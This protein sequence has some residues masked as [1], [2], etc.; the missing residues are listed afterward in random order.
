MFE[1]EVIS[2]RVSRY[3]R[4]SGLVV[5]REVTDHPGAVMIV[6]VDGDQV[7][8]VRQPREAVEE[9][10]LELPAGKMDVLG[11]PPLECA[12]R[13]LAEEVGRRANRWEDLGGFF[14][15]PAIST[16]FIHCFLAEDLVPVSVDSDEEEEIEIVPVHLN[17][18][19]RAIAEVRD[20]KTLIGLLRLA[21]RR[22]A[23]R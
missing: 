17:D 18:L 12:K 16:E 6:P 23:G 1:G 11:E 9:R 7:L 14:V 13:E 8:L 3:R 4:P 5:R 19:D 20:A 21:Q 15:A 22:S 2:V 10:M